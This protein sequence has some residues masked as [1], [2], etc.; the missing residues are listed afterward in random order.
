[1]KLDKIIISCDANPL[2]YKH[3]PLVYHAYKKFFPEVSL[4][5]AF[6]NNAC[7]CFDDYPFHKYCDE[8]IQYPLVKGIPSCNQGKMVRYFTA[9]QYPNKICMIN[10]IDLIPL[11]RDYYFNKLT[12]RRENHLMGVGA[13]LY[14]G[15]KVKGKFPIAYMTGEGRLFKELLNPNNMEWKHYL[16]TFK[17][18]VH[19][20]GKED[21][22]KPFRV[23]SDESLIRALLFRLKGKVIY[24]DKDFTPHVDSITRKGKFIQ[25]RLTRE[26]YIEAHHVMP[27]KVFKGKIDAI[28]KYLGFEYRDDWIK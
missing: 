11:Q 24:A 16:E 26:R 18:F 7:G 15:R 6:V 1:M 13:N 21:I 14:K 19:I 22:L 20:D 4:V 25:K 9:A 28:S 27:Y 10:D 8:F 23:F 3:L 5:F 2:Y 17:G 12:L